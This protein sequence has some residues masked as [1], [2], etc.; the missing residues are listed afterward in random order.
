MPRRR[1][2]AR[3][4]RR[5]QQ[6]VV[7]RMSIGASPNASPT[8]PRAAREIGTWLEGEDDFSAWHGATALPEARVSRMPSRAIGY[9]G[10]RAEAKTEWILELPGARPSCAHQA[11]GSAE[12]ARWRWRGRAAKLSS[13]GATAKPSKRQLTI[14]TRRPTPKY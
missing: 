12:P 14:F 2:A 10:S 3:R 9:G 7:P 8:P 1:A 13:T 6:S 11:G 4:R 5:R